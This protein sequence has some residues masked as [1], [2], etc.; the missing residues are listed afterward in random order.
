MAET[1]SWILTDTEAGIW[2][3]SI[4]LTADDIGT[5]GASVRKRVLR[6][7][8]SDGV[9]VIEVDNGEFSYTILPTR[10]MDPWEPE[11]SVPERSRT[12]KR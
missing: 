7:G 5:A 6:G 4:E 3:E 1:K 8:L 9:E 11:N 10:G 2:T 12:R